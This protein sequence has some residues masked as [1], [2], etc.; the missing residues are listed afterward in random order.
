MIRFCELANLRGPVDVDCWVFE[1]N[2]YHL[3][4]KVPAEGILPSTNVENED[5]LKENG[6]AYRRR[7]WHKARL[8]YWDKEFYEA[9][10]INLPVYVKKGE[11]YIFTGKYYGYVKA[12]K[13]T[14]KKAW[15][16][17]ENLV[18]HKIKEKVEK[19]LKEEWLEFAKI[20]LTGRKEAF[21]I[22][23]FSYAYGAKF[24]IKEDLE[25]KDAENHFKI[26]VPEN[27][28]F[29]EGWGYYAL[30]DMN[31]IPAG[32]TLQISVPDYILDVVIGP[33]GYNI[34]RWVKK[35]GVKS[36]NVVFE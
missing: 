25:L 35:L 9:E 18:D 28:N 12:T 23:P 4:L 24:K 10:E 19:K 34:Q 14:I 32:S 1:N 8:E 26:L 16:L 22:I 17:S 13:D 36:I 20:R 27:S 33:Q 5:I 7:E 30:F 11:E 6:I 3:A 31:K 21:E 29:S 15:E 2:E